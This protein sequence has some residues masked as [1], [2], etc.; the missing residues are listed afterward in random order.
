[1][2]YTALHNHSYYSVLDGFSSPQEYF[3]RAKEIGL[4]G[5]Q[6][7]EHGNQYSWVYFDKL[8]KNYPDIKLIFGAELYECDDINVKNPD[9]RYTH[10]LLTCINEKS[11]IAMND[12]ITRS[13]FDGFYYRPRVDLN[14]LRP[15]GDLFIISSA[16][17]ASKLSREKDYQKCI[18]YIKEY[19]SIFS[20]FFLEIM[21][22]DV[23][24]QIE[25]NKKVLQLSIDTNTDFIISCDSHSATKEDLY[26]QGKLVQVA[27]DEDTVTEIYQDCYL[28]SSDE[29]HAILDSQIGHE[30]VELGLRNTDKIYDLVENVSMPFQSPKLPTYPLPEGY[31]SN[32]EYLKKLTEDGMIKRGFYQLSKKDLRLRQNRLSYELDMIEK[33][34]FDG[35]F[36]I[37]WD[38]INWSKNNDVMV[39]PGRGSAGGSIVCYLLNIVELDPIKYNLIF[40]RFLNPE[41]VSMP[42][43]DLDFSDRDKVIQYLTEKYGQNRV[44]QII[45]YSYITPIVAIKD[46]ARILGIP[47]AISDTISKKFTYETFDECMKNNQD[48]LVKYA[49]YT[50]LFKVASKLYDRVR[51]VSTHAGGVGIVDTNICDYMGMKLGAKG[52]KVIQVDKKMSEEIGIIKFDILGISTLSMIKEVLSY[53][54]IDPWDIDPNNEKFI[55]DKKTYEIIKSTNTNGVFQ[56]ES[57]GMKD[58]LLRL[59][60]D[61]IEDI[62]AILALYRPDSMEF[63]EDYIH[64]KH[65]PKEIKVW[66][67]NMLPLVKDTYGCIVYQEQLMNFVRIFGGR[68]MGGADL[69]RKAIGKKDKNLVKAEADK[70]YQEIKD[71]GYDNDLAVK[72]SDYLSSKGGYMFNLSHSML[73]SVLTLQTAYLKVHYPVQFYTALLNQNKNDYGT[74]N[75]YIVDAINSKVEIVPPN[76]N[77]SG[78]NFTIHN[79]KILFGLEA[80]KGIGSKLVDQILSEKQKENYKNLEDFVAK[81]NPSTSQVV[82]LIKAG[83]IPCK[84]KRGYLLQYANTLFEEKKYNPV[85][86]LPST[87]ILQ[88]KWNIGF[89]RSI[90]KDIKLKEYNA[91]REMH[92]NQQ[93]KEKHK[94]HIDDFTEK[95][96][97]DEE[98]WE[99]ETLSIFLGKNPF[100]KAYEYLT[101]IDD[102][103]VNNKCVIVG[104]ISDVTKKVDRNGKQFAYLNIYS[105]FGLIDTICWHSQ[106]KTYND[107]IKKGNQVALLCKKS[108]DGKFIIEKMKEYSVWLKDVTDK[109]QS[110]L[111]LDK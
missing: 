66:H 77:N 92:Y 8:K 100:E 7:S 85:T 74:L 5:F 32:H 109:N 19:K 81:T 95:Y 98:L 111:N 53:A 83:A 14:M 3:E 13:N 35:Y 89:D 88:E 38:L 76:I 18:E 94:K 58:L 60:P 6:I 1:M 87:K 102:I 33:M 17:L 96:M 57:S 54:K 23:P 82:A 91:F 67:K 26:Y 75:K 93:Q 59:Q 78:R 70:L 63:L 48:L 9:N 34:G 51:H 29:I 15:Y 105:I 28:Q 46:T 99:F 103:D 25:Y 79:N 20:H 55:N 27:R 64:F 73:Y 10:L 110:K 11:R 101:P 97:Q 22:H 41:R 104:I 12:I 52:E 62:S 107:L 50:E 16:C 4:K 61:R 106:Y 43:I 65:N 90:D 24:D 72:I 84:N 45:N 40:E 69:F 86:T 108:D 37:V 2:T 42:D 36:L 71:N 30:N 80:I 56:V 31:S 47:Y 21:P 44:C 49:E 39:G 68:T